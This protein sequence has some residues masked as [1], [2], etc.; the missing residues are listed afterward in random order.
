M[1]LPKKLAMTLLTPS[2]LALLLA[3]PALHA[4]AQTYDKID[5]TAGLSLSDYFNLYSVSIN[6]ML[7]SYHQA[8][9]QYLSVDQAYALKTD[10]WKKSALW[11]L[12]PNHDGTFALKVSHG[13]SGV[14]ELCLTRYANDDQP[15]EDSC[16]IG[17]ENQKIQIVPTNTGA[18]VL[19]FPAYSEC[20]GVR[21]GSNSK[22]Y[23]ITSTCEAEKVNSS[24]L[25]TFNPAK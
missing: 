11:R 25:W 3:Y 15:T 10:Y 23:A 5:S 18:L 24:L 6:G 12:Y 16:T 9:N 13:A 1:K 22:K 7:Y 19:K 21:Y 2:M 4:K 17:N 8:P 20:L 14:D